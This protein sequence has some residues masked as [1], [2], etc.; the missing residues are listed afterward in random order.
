MTDIPK[1]GGRQRVVIENVQ[2]EIDAGR[3]P[4]KRVIG[5]NVDVEADAF[6]DGNDVLAC[7]L[8]YR[9]ASE[10]EW[11]EVPMVPLVNDRWRASFPLTELGQ[12]VYTITAWSDHFLSWRH[13]FERRNDAQDIAMALQGGA[14]LVVAAAARAV[15]ENKLH[16]Q[17][18]G[19]TLRLANLDDGSALA[20][21]ETL[22]S[23]MRRYPDRSF[24]TN[25]PN[26]LPLWV[27]PVKAQYS[28]WY[29]FFPRSCIS[30]DMPHGT[31]SECEK[32]LPYVAEMGFDVVYL[33]PIHPIG[34][35]KRKGKNNALV[36]SEAD[37]GSPWAIGATDGG[38]KSIH[39]LLG[40]LDDFHRLVVKA[41]ELD[42]DIALDI[43]FQ[44]SPDH[45]YVHDHP[46]WFRHR[47]DD[48]IQY[49]ENPPKKYED[50]YPFNF[51]SDAW[52]ALWQELLE[53]FLFWIE[54]GVSIFRVDNPHSKPFPFWEWLIGEV[55][56]AHPQ[57]IFLAEAFTRP[58]IIYHLAKVGFSQSYNYFPWRNTKS[59]LETYFTELTQTD[60]REY[61]RANLWPNTPDILS[62]YLQFGGRPA[63]MIRL[64][65]AA[66]LGA[67][68][69]V[70]GP[71]YE[72][73]EAVPREVG[74]EEY[75]D[76]EKYQVRKWEI[77]RVD[78]LKDFIT[79]INQIR[80]E[81]A[82]LQQDHRLHF[83]EADNEM[84]FCYAKTTPDNAEI[85]LVVVNLD[86]HHTQSGWVTL[87]LEKLGLDKHQ[88]YQM[89]DLLTD[90]R[91]LWNGAR[92]YVEIN[93]KVAPA[94][95]F[96]LH[97]RIR[98]EHDFDYYL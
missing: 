88:S 54:Q 61:F 3:F 67:N 60:V 53:V 50:I 51:E 63:F 16:L 91:F 64:V 27:E 94:H 66:T 19:E 15:D 62:E 17:Q 89:Q 10:T 22:L 52:T 41:G 98:T 86:P 77:A 42:I 87:P 55:K 76:S 59:E 74:G 56:R 84:L 85:I 72:L 58:K 35:T 26:M 36:A 34:L 96:K 39:S 38:H 69:G 43:A 68:Y 97:R 31:F 6:A 79:R 92:N 57:I 65:L 33:P 70:Y 46:E 32:W 5:Q 21:S 18:I 75:L 14:M 23:L 1:I 13:E 11:H 25:Y 24:A 8:R 82:A 95:I 80:R 78:S 4:A 83:F 47:P 49:A 37:V 20:L 73:M 71:A 48:S 2:P 29:E 90:A 9:H 44:C 45:P 28:T 93:P 81:S 40:T 30:G 12:Y 7:V